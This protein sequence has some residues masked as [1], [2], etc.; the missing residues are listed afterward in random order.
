MGRDGPVIKRNAQN[1]DG[2]AD[3]DAD[4]DKGNMWKKK[5]KRKK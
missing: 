1:D 4:G 3:G 2:G 5:K